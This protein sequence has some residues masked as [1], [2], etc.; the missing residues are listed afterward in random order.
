MTTQRARIVGLTALCSIAALSVV[1]AQQ[2][3]FA[4]ATEELVNAPTNATLLSSSAPL[5]RVT[6]SALSPQVR[7]A[8]PNP[9][10]ASSQ[11]LKPPRTTV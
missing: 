5:P 3:A 1:S 8:P 6:R 9:A 11:G 10:K 4:D 2:L 7:L